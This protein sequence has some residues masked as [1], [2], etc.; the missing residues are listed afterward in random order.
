MRAAAALALLLLAVP[1]A[2]D[3][4]PWR[5]AI[6]QPD[7]KR[8]ALLW[9]AW[10]TARAQV[11]EVGHSDEW[12]RLGDL[13][14]PNLRAE[15][16][17]PRPGAYNC[18]SLKLGARTPGLPV[19]VMAKPRPCRIEVAGDNLRLIVDAGP[20]RTAGLLYADGK[21]MIYLG[22]VSLGSESGLFPYRRDA[23]RDQV[24]VLHRI[25]VD[26]WRLEL[27]FPKWESTLDLVEITAP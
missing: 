6:T 20:Q 22:A 1:A 2:A 13:V 5:Q 24:G 18:R 12:T 15:G 4:P 23:E 16:E 11:S 3:P 9:R 27:P 26:R 8:L 7:R 21:R 19:M 14:D 10:T 17:P 25:G